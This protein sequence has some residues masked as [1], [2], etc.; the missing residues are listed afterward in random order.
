M[1]KENKEWVRTRELWR[2]SWY[3]AREPKRSAYRILIT[4][5]GDA[6]WRLFSWMQIRKED[7]K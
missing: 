1:A 7:K 3:N 5:S 2:F 4:D 6:A